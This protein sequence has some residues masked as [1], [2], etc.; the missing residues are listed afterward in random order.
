MK[1]RA[2]LLVTTLPLAQRTKASL[3]LWFAWGYLDLLASARAR[4]SPSSAIAMWCAPSSGSLHE[5]APA[6]RRRACGHGMNHS[7][8]ER[9]LV[10]NGGQ[11]ELDLCWKEALEGQLVVQ[12]LSGE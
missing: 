2:G 7:R 11:A 9:R 3:G 6:S 12:T 8:L 1:A 10:S 5:C 4:P